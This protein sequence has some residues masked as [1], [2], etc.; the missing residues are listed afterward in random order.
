MS[1]SDA[2]IVSSCNASRPKETSDGTAFRA[3]SFEGGKLV[4]GC[5]SSI[6]VHGVSAAADD[7]GGLVIAAANSATWVYHWTSLRFH[8]EMLLKD[9]ARHNVVPSQMTPVPVAFGQ[10]RALVAAWMAG[11]CSILDLRALACV[12]R[13]AFGE[14]VGSK[15]ML[16]GAAE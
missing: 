14:S 9:D 13:F 15:C 7:E 8:G 6:G 10:R 5:C 12:K 1:T 2:R 3:T 16:G 11:A 4:T